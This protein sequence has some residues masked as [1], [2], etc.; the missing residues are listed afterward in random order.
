M[1]I[2]PDL[3]FLITSSCFYCALLQG[4]ISVN[5]AERI[6]QL[7]SKYDNSNSP[8]CVVGVI[9]DGQVTYTKGFGMANIEKGIPF[10]P[11]TE[12][13]IGS[14]TKQ[15]TAT[16]IGLLVQEGKV[17]L[18]EDIRTYLPELSNYDQG[19]TIRHLLHHTSGIW[20]YT[21]LSNLK[22]KIYKRF[23]TYQE[24]LPLLQK[25]STLNFSPNT[26][27]LYS[28]S[29][30][31]LLQEI[32]RRV[33]SQSLQE[34]ANENIFEPLK[35]NNTF[36]NADFE[37]ISSTNT[38]GY[39]KDGKG[40]IKPNVEQIGG[41]S[42]ELIQ[43]NLY[44]LFLW[45]QN[46]YHHKVGGEA[47]NKML[48]TTGVLENGDTI[49]YA[50]GLEIGKYLGIKYVTHG[51]SNL[52]FDSDIIRFP[53]HKKSIIILSNSPFFNVN[54]M[55]YSIVDIVLEKQIKEAPKTESVPT[56]HLPKAVL[57]KYCG[58]YWNTKIN[59]PRYVY[60]R[61]DTIRYNRPDRYESP[62][63]PIGNHT[64][65]MLNSSNKQTASTVRFVLKKDGKNELYF[66]TKDGS[67][68]FSYSFEKASSSKKYLK[69]FEGFFYS[70]EIEYSFEVK[71]LDRTLYL[72]TSTN[73]R[74][75]LNPIKADYF[76]DRIGR[77]ITFIK[78]E[79]QDIKGFSM[80]FSRVKGMFFQKM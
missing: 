3:L 76:V 57:K 60:L 8:G 70:E 25:L 74:Y 32:V 44:D 13:C 73:G 63:V 59:Q 56:V 26:Q 16:C 28:N 39:R 14:V 45:D 21:T 61:N 40:N 48:Q 20:D 35:M 64:F 54:P 80:S 52:G 72:I 9:E 4:Q 37:R 17:R 22:G 49:N 75:K 53:D 7:F 43:T 6:D 50:F 36:Y 77:G 34:F 66:R 69:Q 68:S 38:I 46:F 23:T 29:G 71:F 41:V 1:K 51:G 2:F 31:L 67:E 65:R 79:N 12:F 62:L 15:F 30:F 24:T 11:N 47:L 42:N 58:P 18:D 10:T 33:S 19:I 27:H 5:Q 78:N 55:M